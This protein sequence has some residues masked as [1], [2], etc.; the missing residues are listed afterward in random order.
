MKDYLAIDQLPLRENTLSRQEIR[1][2]AILGCIFSTRL[3][4]LF[5]ILPVFSLYAEHLPNATPFLIGIAL[6]I[7]GLTQACLQIPFGM[8]SDKFGRKRIISIGLLIFAI[9]SL[10]AACSTDIWGII[11]GRALQGAG[12][13]GSTIMALTADLTTPENRSKAMAIIGI[14]IGFSFALAMGIGPILNNWMGISS[15]FWLTAMLAIIGIAILYRYIPTPSQE[16]FHRDTEVEPKRFREVLLNTELLR[17]NVGIFILHAVLTASFI[18]IPLA[19]E[20]MAYER[21]E[22]PWYLYIVL[23]ILSFLC[24]LPWL[25]V[26]ERKNWLKSLFV[27]SIALLFFAEILFLFCFQSF[28]MFIISLF[29]FFMAFSY[30]EATLPA[31]VSRLAPANSKGTAMGVYSTSQFLGIFLGGALGGALYGHFGIESIFISSAIALSIWFFV[32]LS[33]QKPRNVTNFMLNVG[34]VTPENREKIKQHLSNI[35]GII[36]ITLVDE[37]CIAYL[38]IDKNL[39]D[40]EKLHNFSMI[41]K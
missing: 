7:Y 16:Q 23:L 37:D 32:A 30:L 25:R 22:N 38:K 41:L 40:K 9:G 33:M 1:Y 24:M 19:L 27:F 8:A 31:L 29:L 4:G 21:F 3:L 28:F 10:L 13:I 15:I 2:A 35:R 12:A 18:A 11:I 6:G 20:N 17:L 36:E 14:L 26:A 39:I 34:R 5:M